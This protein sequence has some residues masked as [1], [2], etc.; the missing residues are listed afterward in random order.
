MALTAP[1]LVTSVVTAS[2]LPPLRVSSQG[3]G[4]D[5]FRASCGQHHHAAAG[6]Q[7]PGSRLTETAA[8]TGD[9]DDLACN[10]PIHQFLSP[11]R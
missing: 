4:L 6:T 10:V 9:R 2:A 8:G 11:S 3:K 5:A 1:Q 7:V